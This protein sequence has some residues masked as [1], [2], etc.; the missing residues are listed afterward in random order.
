MNTD[1]LHKLS[2]IRAECDRV[3][4]LDKLATPGPWVDTEHNLSAFGPMHQVMQQEGEHRW[5]INALSG[6]ASPGDSAFIATSRQFTP[7]AAKVV[8]VAI[9]ALTLIAP[10]PD[11]ELV[12]PKAAHALDALLVLADTFDHLWT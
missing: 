6:Q 10:S 1:L 11:A 12:T 5:A 7:A 3:I 8:L 2:L 4:E 9:E